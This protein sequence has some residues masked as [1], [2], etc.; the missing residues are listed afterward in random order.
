M[1][2]ASAPPEQT[3]LRRGPGAGPCGAAGASCRDQ[4]VSDT[5]PSAGPFDDLRPCPCRHLGNFGAH[6]P[7][8]FRVQRLTAPAASPAATAVPPAHL[9]PR[10]HPHTPVPSEFAR[11]AAYRRVVGPQTQGRS[12]AL[13]H[14]RRHGSAP[15]RGSAGIP[16]PR[17]PSWHSADWAARAASE[18]AYK[19]RVN[20][21]M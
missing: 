19:S 14:Y 7:L 6:R 10:A 5:M 21:L 18:S 1:G 4:P 17:P 3:L 20:S 15:P 13:T 9:R 8:P 16:S 12:V 11:A 2:T